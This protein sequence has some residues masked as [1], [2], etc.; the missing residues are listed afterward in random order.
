MIEQRRQRH[1][2][3]DG[4]HEERRPRFG[5]ERLANEHHG[6]EHQQP[7]RRIATSVFGKVV[8]MWLRLDDTDFVR[9]ANSVG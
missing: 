6:N 8:R 5:F 2:G 7:E 1:D 3:E 9:F 4:K